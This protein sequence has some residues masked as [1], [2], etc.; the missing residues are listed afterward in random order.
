MHFKVL[1]KIQEVETI[2]TG[3]GITNLSRLNKVYGKA[4]WRKLKGICKVEL[5]DG[6]VLRAEVHWYEGHGIGKK[7]IKI[8]KYL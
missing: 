1:G 7:E 5:E 8:K 6:T 3:H 4:H 2:A